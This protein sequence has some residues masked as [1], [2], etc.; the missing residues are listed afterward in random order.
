MSRSVDLI[1]SQLGRYLKSCLISNAI[2]GTTTWK[3]AK[4]LPSEKEKEN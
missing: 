3:E 4:V 1:N 2:K